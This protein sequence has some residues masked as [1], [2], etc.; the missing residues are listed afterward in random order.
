[1]AKGRVD[2]RQ[3][4]RRGTGR[5]RFYD[6]HKDTQEVVLEALK[7]AREGLDTDSDTRA[8]EA[9]CLHFLTTGGAPRPAA[10][11]PRRRLPADM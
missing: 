6:A 2:V 11:P 8:L 4:Q 7:M 5:L 3:S 10:A 9:I 1:M